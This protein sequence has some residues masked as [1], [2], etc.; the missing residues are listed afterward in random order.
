M[1]ARGIRPTSRSSEEQGSLSCNTWSTRECRMGCWAVISTVRFLNKDP[2]ESD[3]LKALLAVFNTSFSLVFI[4]LQWPSTYMI[5]DRWS[6]CRL[7]SRCVTSSITVDILGPSRSLE[8]SS[9]SLEIIRK[10]Y[11][12]LNNK[13]RQ[14]LF[15]STTFTQNQ[16]HL[17]L[18][19]RTFVAE[20]SRTDNIDKPL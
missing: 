11:H 10:E 16:T 7:R 6:C 3:M 1:L 9:M 14:Y 15:A 2:L 17:A 8:N 19:L 4:R 20:V 5:S 12:W 13:N 18:R